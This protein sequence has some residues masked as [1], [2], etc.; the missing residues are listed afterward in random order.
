M[1]PIELGDLITALKWRYATKIFD[2]RRKIPEALVDGLLDALVLSPSSFGMQ[3]WKF[4]VVEDPALRAR[5][6]PHSWDQAQVTDA[7]HFIVL[8]VRETVTAAHVDQWIARLAEVRGVSVETLAAYRVRM[9][10]FLSGMDDAQTFV[11]ASR[12]AYIA[13]GQLMTCAAL[14]GVDSCPMEGFSPPAYD[15][16][17]GLPGTGYRAVVACALGYRSADDKHARVP[18]TR[19]D[20][21][22]VVEHR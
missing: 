7:S 21:V 15:E 10:S 20:R 12:Q 5:L 2:P 11:W 8:A 18:K 13:L 14:L 6:Q 4:I 9:T 17:L 3:P 22:Q 19:Y 1:N 16:A